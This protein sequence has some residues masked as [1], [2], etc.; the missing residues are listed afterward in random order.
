VLLVLGSVVVLIP[1][2]VDRPK[3]G[4]YTVAQ[5]VLPVDLWVRQQVPID[6]L[7]LALP[8]EAAVAAKACFSF[9]CSPS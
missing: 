3:I 1:V 2:H 9:A 5:L 7:V 8:G 6:R 4:Q